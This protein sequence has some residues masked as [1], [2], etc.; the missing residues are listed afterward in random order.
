MKFLE[1]LK[2]KKPLT[3]FIKDL[4]QKATEKQKAALRHNKRFKHNVKKA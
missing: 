4:G 1:D 3:R 2:E